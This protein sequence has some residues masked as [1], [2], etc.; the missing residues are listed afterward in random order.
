MSSFSRFIIQKNLIIPVFKIPYIFHNHTLYLCKKQTGYGIMKLL[1][2]VVTLK[3]NIQYL[4]LLKFNTILQIKEWKISI[5]L[6]K[7]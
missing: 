4:N 7:L 5:F 1:M 6:V 2:C 3:K